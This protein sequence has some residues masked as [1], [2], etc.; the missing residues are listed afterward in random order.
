MR[1]DMDNS[2]PATEH[3]SSK[4]E[5]RIESQAG[6]NFLYFP[7]KTAEAQDIEKTSPELPS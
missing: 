1:C 7:E 2:S 6:N 5:N 4:R 3:N